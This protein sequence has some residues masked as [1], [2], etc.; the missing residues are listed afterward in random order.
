[1]KKTLLVTSLATAALLSTTSSFA[2]DGNINFTGKIQDTTCVV[3]LAAG[4]T[5]ISVPMGDLNK[6]AFSGAGSTGT[7]SKFTINLK[8]CPATYTKATVEFDGTAAGNDKKVLALTAGTTA[9]PAATGVGIQISDKS[10]TVL[11]LK[12]PSAS[13]DLLTG[14]ADINKLDFTARYVATSAT[15]TSGVANSSATFNI[16]YN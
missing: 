7:S 10:D 5:G 14:A 8:S 4:E 2:A 16:K 3:D 15:V 1:M 13:Y 11:A 12:T 9:D 6:T